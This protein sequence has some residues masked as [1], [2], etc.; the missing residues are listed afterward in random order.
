M[1]AASDVGSRF[2]ADPLTPKLRGFGTTIFAEMSALAVATDSIN[3]GQGFPDTDGPLAV[4]DAAI[5]AIRSGHN[6]YPPGP[7]TPELRARSPAIS[8]AS[9]GSTT[10]PTARYSS[11]P[12]PPR[13]LPVRSSGCSTRATR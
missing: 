1:S 12:E 4:L 13:R 3:L 7:G 8:S 10:I 6:Q 11:P 2:P 5:D 9:T